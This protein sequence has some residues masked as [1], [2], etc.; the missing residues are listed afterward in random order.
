MA[1]ENAFSLLGLPE[2]FA[3]THEAIEAAWK[4][5]IALVHPDRFANRPEAERIVAARWAERINDA[6]ARLLNPIQRAQ[7]LLARHGVGLDAETDTAMPVDFLMQQ[8]EWREAASD[9][10]TNRVRD[11]A[12]MESAR[13]VRLL[14]QAIDVDSDWQAARD[15]ARRLVFITKLLQSL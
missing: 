3:L 13:L 14:A 8:M 4:Q 12:Q 5:A 10:E 2:Q 6:K 15:A 11:E 7:D 1:R 9:G